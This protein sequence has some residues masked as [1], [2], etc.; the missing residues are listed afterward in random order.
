MV[1]CGRR[2]EAAAALTEGLVLATAA[3]DELLTTAGELARRAASAPRELV[4]LTK[5]SLQEEPA[6]DADEAMAL[7][8]ERQLWSLR[9]PAT[10]DGLRAAA[11]RRR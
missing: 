1:L 11:R 9:L 7:E 8:E 2:L 3:D 6:L 10:A 4:L 5:R